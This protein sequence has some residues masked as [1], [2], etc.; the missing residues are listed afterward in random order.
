M[1]FPIKQCR[2]L[3]YISLSILSLCLAVTITPVRASV[4]VSA[5]SALNASASTNQL[6]QGRNLYRSGRFTEAVKI[7]QTAAQQYHTQGDRTNEAL[8]LSYLSL[9][10]QEL[11]QWEAAS[12]SIEQS[13]KLLQ[14]SI[15]SADAILWA[16]ALNTQANLQL[17]N[18]K[19]ETALEN[20]QQAEK[21]YEQ[22]GDKMGSLGSQINQAQALQS[23]GFYR[24]SKQQL[25][26]LTQKLGA[27]PDSEIKVSGLRSLGL[28]LQ[29]IGDSAKSQQVLE[30]SL[31]IARKIETT[32]QLSSILLS[33]GKTAVDLHDPEAALDYFQQAQQVASNP[34]DRLQARLAQFKLFLD[35]NKSELATP[36]AP[37][38][39]QQLAELPPSHTSL[40]AAINFVA[41]LNR[42]SNPDQIVPLKDLAQLMAVTV[43]SA[44]QIQDAQ[45]E[46]YAL[47]Q[48]GKLYRR[49]QQLSQAQELTQKSL[50]I[51]RQLQAEDIIAQSAWQ[52]G[53]LYKEQGDRSE[54]I[55]AYTEAVKALKSIR[56]DLVAVNP[57]VQF[58]FREGVEPVYRE[59]V[60]LLL[61]RQPSQAALIQARDLIEALQ[62]AE[63]DNFFREACLDR[64]QQIDQVDPNAT[65]IY[66]IILPDRLAIILSKTGQPLRYYATQ[67]S[68]ADIEQT[69]D[70]LLVSFNPV[71]DSQERDRL[72]QEI[73]SWLIRP[74]EIEQAFKDSK[75]LV[76]VLD[77][78]LRNIP[79][80]A[81]Y[82]GKQY[83]IEKYAVALSPGMQLMA[84]RSLQPN[85]IGAIVGGIS[86]SRNG[87]SALPAV[88]SE[89]KQI[90]KT[91]PS[92]TLLNQQFTSQALANRVKSSSADIVHLATHGQFSSRLEDT[93][94]LTW[95]GEVNVKELSEL[96]KNRGNE[97]SKA[98][99]L[100]VLS[101]CDT[102]AGDDRAVLGL[103]G[104]AV[105][106]G[107]RSTIATLWPVKDKAAEMLMTRFYDQLRQPK[108]SKAEAL[109]Q[110]QIN[111]I[112]QTDFHD[113]FFWSAFVLVGNWL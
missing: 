83:L 86:E 106:S 39:L 87:F 66:P 46:A 51:A 55:S 101:A 58:S 70:K 95:D 49:T 50:N 71:S 84:A 30:Q 100:L 24:R 69:L 60:G 10:Q 61:D 48:W 77:G 102:A 91:V 109:R 85:H 7:W 25:E 96:L 14:T 11:N 52:V 82:D 68:Q 37:Q 113:P 12:Q 2:W 53:Q 79:I 80:A 8:S 33:L 57:D 18:G 19:A 32:P 90:S 34:G 65:V 75:T 104:L 88:E 89:V 64:S 76:F 47:H 29:V 73:Y 4:Q 67:K 56:G 54:A 105:K 36:L 35:Y 110:A 22:A 20:W 62:V 93:F 98:I 94:L 41:T 40:Y 74:A 103:A 72:S 63:L 112:R 27:M 5:N 99:E 78:R 17:H 15:P 97:P 23:L 111:M 26:M 16:Q 21:Y 81:L 3:L 107:A 44:Q 28:A 31:A 1:A 45:A 43:K 59:L 13:L 38:L 6:E 42:Q 9:A 92:S 108:M